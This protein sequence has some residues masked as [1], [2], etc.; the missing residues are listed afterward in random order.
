MLISA[1]EFDYYLGRCIQAANHVEWE[2]R[3]QSKEKQVTLSMIRN[4]EFTE[5][6]MKYR[7]PRNLFHRSP[8]ETKK[9][10]GPTY[11]YKTHITSIVDDRVLN[12]R[13]QRTHCCGNWRR[14]HKEG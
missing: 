11:Q 4:P 14:K 9:K 7:V 8:H 5:W 13:V 1:V 10:R 2:M 12:D 3:Q 6:T